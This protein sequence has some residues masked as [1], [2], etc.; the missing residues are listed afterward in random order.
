MLRL[1]GVSCGYGETTVL[2]E[3]GFHVKKGEILSLLG[4]NGSGKSTLLKAIVG[5]LPYKGKIHIQE[6]E[7]KHLRAKK[8]A[9][10]LAYVPQ[11]TFV[12]FDFSVLDIVLTGRFHAAS[13][14]LSYTKKDK[15]IAR[16]SLERAGIAHFENRIYRTLSGGER[17][18]VLIARALAQ[19][20]ALIV[21]DEPVTGLDLGNQMRLL[22][23]LQTLTQEGYAIVQTTHHPDHALRISDAVVWIH[24]GK[25]LD[26]GMPESVIN[27]NRIHAIYGVESQ[28]VIDLRGTRHLL[29]L[30]FTCKETPCAF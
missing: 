1:E 23:T 13:F 30:G 19:Q 22:D 24:E 5:L 7:A 27:A 11:S 25:V 29:P 10:L 18:L 28:V 14:G 8:R 21:M 12:P 15:E 20:S 2:S 17:Q 4:A 6:S 9:A 16:A 3:V 26:Y